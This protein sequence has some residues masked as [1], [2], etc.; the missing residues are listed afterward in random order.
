LDN[1]NPSLKIVLDDKVIFES[2]GKWLYPLFDL[3][4]YL[5]DHKI[6]ISQA[7]LSDK[8]IGKAAA[9]L[10]IRL[11]AGR[12]HGS[13]IS[14]LAVNEFTKA[15][16]PH[17]YNQLVNRISCKTE[18]ILASVTDPEEGYRILRKHANLQE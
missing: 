5:R 10:I 1:N 18:E 7:C 6:D 2:N 17:S 12:V 16:I 4:D 3:E 11:G 13:L 15:N 8:V 9:I 14:D